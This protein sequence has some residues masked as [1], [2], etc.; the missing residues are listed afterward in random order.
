M[1]TCMNIKARFFLSAIAALLL[2][3]CTQDNAPEKTLE[4]AVKGLYAAAFSDDGKL[5]VVGSIYHGGSL[6][7]LADGEKLYSW[8]HRQ[9][10]QSMLMAADFS[11]DGNWAMTA[12][13][14]SLVL[15]NTR[16]GE[17]VRYW[18]APGEV[19][20][21]ALSSNGDFAL[22]GLSDHSAV[23]FD[24]KRGGIKRTFV[25]GNRVRSVDL[26]SDG[27]LAITGSEDYTATLWDLASGKQLQQIKHDD[28]VQMVA[29]SPD[30]RIAMSAAKYDKAVLWDTRTGDLLGEIPLGTEKLRRGLRFTT[31]RF[32]S[33]GSQ[34]LT[35]RPDEI[36]QL[37]DTASVQLVDSWKIP[38]RDKWQP[39]GA[40]VIAVAF[41]PNDNRYYAAG[42]NGMLHTLAR[43]VVQ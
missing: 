39:T 34:L 27:R 35:G 43:Q 33:D 31:A 21:I 24:V 12:S 13:I 20:S 19:L 23:L 42:S 4:V 26:S 29:I 16:E 18:T 30:G 32:N 28:D 2:T 38:K 37:W 25:H 8:N 9:G 11:P 14:N 41:D 17:A 1:T 6:W 7:R 36:V 5:A 15:W 22:L 3:A 10:E 40:A